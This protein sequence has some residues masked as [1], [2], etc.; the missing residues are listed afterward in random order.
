MLLSRPEFAL[1][2]RKH[3]RERSHGSIDMYEAG[4]RSSVPWSCEW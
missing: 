3:E 4:S 2:P 1:E